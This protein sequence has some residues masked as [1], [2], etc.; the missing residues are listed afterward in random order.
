MAYTPKPNCKR[1]VDTSKLKVGVYKNFN[2]L[3]LALGW[4]IPIDS[5]QRRHDWKR[6]QHYC[7]IR[8]VECSQR[9]EITEIYDEI[10]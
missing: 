4:S 10:K 2:E 7:D 9:I 1:L 5:R 6:L 3:C 8:R